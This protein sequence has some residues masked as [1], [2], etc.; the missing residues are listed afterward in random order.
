MT[1]PPETVPLSPGQ[2]AIWV[3]WQLDRDH[4]AH[5]IPMVLSVR[6]DLDADRLRTAFRVLGE[7]HPQLRARISDSGQG[8]VLDWSDAP[9]IEV[10]ESVTDDRRDDAVRR[11]WQVPFDLRTGPLCRVELMYGPDWTV[12]LVVVHHLVFDGAS[13]LVFLEAL[14]T[15]YADGELPRSG[16]EPFLRRL[17]ERQRRLVATAEGDRHRAYWQ[18]ALASAADLLPLPTGDEEPRFTVHSEK[19]PAD[20]AARLRERATEL[21]V[22]Y[23]TVLLGGYF[24]L[25]RRHTGG[26]RV[27]AFLPYHGR[28]PDERDRIGYFVNPLPVTADPGGCDTYADLIRQ[29]RVRVKEALAHGDLPFPEIMRAA[30][31][32]GPQARERTHQTVFQ[33]WNAGLRDGLDVQDAP[34]VHDGRTARLRLEDIESTAGYRLAVMVR[35]DSAGTRLVWKDPVGS[36]GAKVIAEMAADYRAILETIADDPHTSLIA[37]A[38]T[39]AVPTSNAPAPRAGAGVHPAVPKMTE[40]WR[41]VLGIDDIE[42]VDSFFELGGHSLLAESLVLAVSERFGTKVGIRTLFDFPRLADFTE[43]VAG[44]AGVPASGFQR[45]IWLAERLEAGSG[46]YHVPLAWRVAG[47]LDPRALADALA[48]MV[49]R[50]E[51]LRTAFV[52]HDGE[53]LQVIGPPWRPVVEEVDL[54]TEGDTEAVLTRWLRAAAG[55]ALEPSSGRL[56]TAALVDTGPDGQVLFLLLHHLICDGE[57]VGL[58]LR[59]LDEHYPAAALTP[60]EAPEEVEPGQLTATGTGTEAVLAEIWSDLLG[61]AAVR[62]DD[63]FFA[64]GGH[65]MLTVRMVNA[66]ATRLGARIPIRAVY[67]TADLAELAG[68]IDAALGRQPE[69]GA[70][71]APPDVLPA[72][73]HQWQIWLAEQ[74]AAG[75]PYNV[76]LAW[77]TGG[78]LDAALLSE[79]LARLVDGHEILRTR[80]ELRGDRLHQI[81]GEAWTPVL[82]QVTDADD[83]LARAARTPFEPASGRLLRAALADLGP[84]G[85]VL[86]LGLHHLVIDGAS[87][88]VL[89]RELSRYYSDAAA[90]RPSAAPGTQY[91]QVALAR[92]AARGGERERTDLDFWHRRL[93]GV[94]SMIE[95]PAPRA[96]EPDGIVPVD[97]PPGALTRLRGTGVTW[98]TVFA[99]ALSEAVRRWTGTAPPTIAVPVSIR[100]N[101]LTDVLGP[102]LN[103]VVVRTGAADG[104]LTAM[105]GEVLG[106]IEHAHAPF[107]DVLARLA[108]ARRPDRVPYCDVML[109]MNLRTERRAVLGEAELVPYVTESVLSQ[110]AR[111]GLVLTVAEQ[112]GELSA[113]LSYPGARVAADDART[114]A[115]YLSEEVAAAAVP[116]RTPAP[117]PQYREF[118]AAQAHARSGEGHRADLDY[119]QERLTGAPAYVGFEDPQ[120][121]GPDGALAVPVG[122][123]LGPRLRTL[124]ARHGITPFMTVAACLAV[125]VGAWNGRDDIVVSTRMTNRTRPEYHEVLGPCLNTVV[126]RSGTGPGL[127]D[128]LTSM[129]AAV[130]EATEHAEAP[131]EDVLERLN[132][133]RRAGRTPY[134]DVVLALTTES[135]DPVLGGCRLTPL[136]VGA[137]ATGFAGKFGLSAGVT[138]TGDRI[139]VR[140]GYRGDRYR[141]ADMTLFAARFGRL[142]ELTADNP[143]RPVADLIA[144]LDDLGRP[145]RPAPPHAP[146]STVAE[147]TTARATEEIIARLWTQVLGIEE[148]GRQD[149]FFDRGGTSMTL[150]KVHSRL[151]AELD[152][153]VP[154]TWLFEYPTISA[155]AAAISGDTAGPRR[156]QR[157]GR[158]ARP[159]A[160]RS[161]RS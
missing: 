138:I 121:D 4:L 126:L 45:R 46:A 154:I 114:V 87:V 56:L 133:P 136:D 140:L 71:D 15:A 30:G 26:D 117:V 13:L 105:Q 145:A 42:P 159:A 72:T 103:T 148:I 66:V 93:N 12:V 51:I 44:P 49:A 147:S 23:V 70:A 35:D 22:S 118:T 150:A 5:I 55:R 57:S 73:D 83:W 109:D 47:R 106:A 40:V 18:A 130:L 119:W 152:R 21:G 74:V 151:S 135:G 7:A 14:T 89:A 82:D 77:R 8:P 29:A 94:P 104:G 91:R 76:C 36:L 127:L 149:N 81:V 102:Q 65:S 116:G 19:L 115:R 11:A 63:S 142:L 85:M 6:G 86:M 131:F 96:P 128:V 25:L 43:A 28:R 155:L 33:Y 141:P 58:L 90:D 34:L 143:D 78:K 99:H 112:D 61:G 24:A 124:H 108:P 59:G 64:L 107:D 60:A 123:D 20:L 129:R 39:A 62:R 92:A 132:P 100:Q 146:A 50:H 158:R 67:D 157:Q 113:V 161:P 88:P 54:S 98:F 153:R 41:E 111:Y 27:M 48:A 53:L 120:A 75:T 156:P 2:A 122:E 9:H 1:T 110:V 160:A 80:F 16:P 31:L 95:F 101:G 137:G 10:R 38:S 125:E 144:V 97:L 69:P 134:A 32:T 17:T 79:A 68:V 139:R 84:D 3:S 37:A 52:E